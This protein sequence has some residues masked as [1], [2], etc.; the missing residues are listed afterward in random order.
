MAVNGAFLVIAAALVCLTACEPKETAASS[1]KVDIIQGVAYLRNASADRTIKATYSCGGYTSQSV[2]LQPG[3]SAVSD[4]GNARC[5]KATVT[6]ARYLD[7]K[8]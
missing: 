4:L 5:S 6:S 7:A 2:T 1:V 3:E 8:D